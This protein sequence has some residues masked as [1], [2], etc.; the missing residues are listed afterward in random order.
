MAFQLARALGADPDAYLP[1]AA[2]ATIGDIVPLTGEN[3][4]IVKRGLRLMNQHPPVCVSALLEEARLHYETITATQVAFM[5][6]PRINAAGRMDDA[7][8]A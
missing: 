4:S 1:T 7:M 8:L 5:L 2:I 6:V 3:R